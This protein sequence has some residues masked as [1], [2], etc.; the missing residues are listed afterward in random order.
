[1]TGKQKK[2]RSGLEENFANSVPLG[3]FEFEPFKV[4]Y[5]T[6]RHYIPDFVFNGDVL[7]ECKGYFRVGDTQKYKAIRD[8]LKS[9]ELIFFLS[10][11]SKR[12]RKG[13]KMNMGQ[14]CEKEG[15]KHYSMNTIDNL[16]KYLELP[17]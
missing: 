8:C 3:A 14:W 12:L 6:Q 16:L 10:D 5:Q 7:I 11:P 1:M 9:G 15:F 17:K 2:Y 13:A 4:P